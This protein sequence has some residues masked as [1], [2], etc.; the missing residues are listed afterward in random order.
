MNELIKETGG[1]G[2]AKKVEISQE[3]EAE[4]KEIAKKEKKARKNKIMKN[5]NK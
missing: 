3:H 1:P 2:Y 5:K 4:F